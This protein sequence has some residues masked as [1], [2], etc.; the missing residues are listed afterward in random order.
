MATSRLDG[1]KPPQTPFILKYETPISAVGSLNSSL[2]CFR[3]FVEV[4]PPN[5]HDGQSSW[6][7]ICSIRSKVVM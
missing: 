4:D 5:L 6:L 2:N 7:H 1:M 3:F